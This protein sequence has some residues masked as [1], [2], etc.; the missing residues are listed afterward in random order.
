MAID[1]KAKARERDRERVCDELEKD[2]RRRFNDLG[3][4]MK[5]VL[6]RYAKENGYSLILE[7]GSPESSV[8]IGL[9]DITGG[10]VSLYARAYPAKP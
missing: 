7:A 3:T 5:P 8:L 1:I 2:R 10:T 6:E 9:N 4:R